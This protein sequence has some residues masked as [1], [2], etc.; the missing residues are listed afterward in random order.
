LIFSEEVDNPKTW[1]GLAIGFAHS[2]LTCI[3]KAEITKA[4]EILVKKLQNENLVE[5]L[6]LD[7]NFNEACLLYISI[8]KL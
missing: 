5:E 7:V 4:Y 2:N 1:I 3:T 6:S 8:A